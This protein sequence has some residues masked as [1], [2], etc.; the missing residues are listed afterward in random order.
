MKNSNSLT[1]NN[2]KPN[3]NDQV[4]RFEIEEE[5]I[6]GEE[7]EEGKQTQITLIEEDSDD[8]INLDDIRKDI[9]KK[10]SM[11]LKM[12]FL[13]I[14][15]KDKLE[16]FKK[17]PSLSLQNSDLSKLDIFAARLNKI[18]YQLFDNEIGEQ[19]KFN[20][21]KEIHRLLSFLNYQLVSIPSFTSSEYQ[22]V[23]YCLVHFILKQGKFILF[24]F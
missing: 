10:S 16:D 5:E 7:E 14:C 4:L 6:E 19:I 15:D 22:N 1:K 21:W 17:N 18:Y 11:K 24:I 8:S 12:F 23:L 20:L 3:E 9:E 13:S 2:P